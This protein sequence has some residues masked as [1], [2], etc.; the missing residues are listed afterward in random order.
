MPES[1]PGILRKILPL[2]AGALLATAAGCGTRAGRDAK[3]WSPDRGDGTYRNPVLFADYSDPDTVR[4][5]EHFYLVSSSFNCVPAL[6][7][8]R[9]RDLVNWRIVA[10]VAARL[11]SPMFDTPQHGKGV[12]APSLRH[13]RGRFWVYYGDPDL[14][15]FMSTAERAEGPWEPP[16]LVQEARGWI[17]P[18]P[19]FDDDGS[20]WL[21]HAWAKSRAG[22]NG[23]LTMRRLSPDGRRILGEGTTVFEGGT[24][25]P[26][27]EGPKIY[28][29]D[30]WYYIF[31]PA[32]GVSRGWQVVLR[33]RH[34]LGPYEDRV[35][36][37]QGRTDVNGP[38]Q[39]AWVE[40]S[41]GESWFLHF[42]DRGAWGR[43]VHLE[44]MRWKDG[45][46][47]IGDDPD[48]DG[49]GEPVASWRKPSVQGGTAVE[50][51]ATSDDFD[52]PGL[53][54]QW[55]WPA[56]PR[57]E[58]WSLAERRGWLRLRAA[59]ATGP[60]ATLWDQPRVLL[61]KLTGPA[62]TATTSVELHARVPGTRA[63]L[64]AMGRDYAYLALEATAGGTRA[65]VVVCRDAD[66]GGREVQ[67][68][69]VPLDSPA[70]Q[71]RLSVDEGA[72]GRF[73]FSG[74]GH[75]FEPI[76]EA[77]TVKGGV[78]VGARV[79]LFALSPAAE[80]PPAHADFDWFR[81]E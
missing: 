23:V 26:T 61:Q 52:G 18:C 49:V 30:G 21:V 1:R 31:A 72:I 39:G 59:P 34:L 81:V 4:V 19:L 51:P 10:H 62:Y 48:G 54:M 29:R 8:L 69:T 12:W 68:A 5:G 9:S 58:W 71:L 40:T 37:A 65:L 79:G 47:V 44:P 41:G 56:N 57:D 36:L 78:W 16:T 27:I 80:T 76:G 42:Q 33:S 73:S 20:V 43:V 15:I 38:H 22:F 2:F 17:D 46:P 28:K 55:Q 7:V 11:P 14:G 60:P 25:H 70:G 32:G 3:S 35:V 6:P 67:V 63:G 75:R 13:H 74:D 45:W 53:G 66:A 50:T 64:V 77:F 24:R